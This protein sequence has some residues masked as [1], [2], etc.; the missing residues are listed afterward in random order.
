MKDKTKIDPEKL[1]EFYAETDGQKKK[2]E[3]PVAEPSPKESASGP[4]LYQCPS[5]RKFV[6]S[7]KEPCP[8]CGYHGYIPMTEGE[9]RR[10]RWILFAVL[11]ALALAV[12]FLF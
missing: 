4:A 8:Y 10:I 5:C 7:R 6:R 11:L 3:E 1:A 9:T 2:P 12:Y